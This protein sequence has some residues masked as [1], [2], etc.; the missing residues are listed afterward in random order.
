MNRRGRPRHIYCDRGTNFV[1]TERVLCEELQN[2]DIEQIAD[3]FVGPELSFHFNPPLSPH[4]GGSWK[5]LVKAVEIALHDAL[6]S[7]TPTD[8]LLRSCLISAE[9]IVNSRPLTY[10]P[11][12]SEESEALT[13]NHF[14]VGCSNGDE[15]MAK[16]NNDAKLEVKLRSVLKRFKE[17]GLRLRADK[18]EFCVCQ[19]EFLGFLITEDGISPTNEKIEAIQEAP[20]PTSKL[21][22]QAFLGMLNFFHLFLENKATVAEP[23]HKGISWKWTTEEQNAFDKLKRMLLSYKNLAHYDEKKALLLTC[24]ANPYG[25]GAVLSHLDECGKEVPIAF[26]SRTL[27][28]VIPPRMLRWILILSSYDYKF[29]YVPG[30]QIPHADA[31]SRLPLTSQDKEGPPLQ[32][33]LMLESVPKKS[34]TAEEIAKKTKEDRILSKV[35]FW[36]QTD[37]TDD[38]NKVPEEL[39]QF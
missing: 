16:L 7:R 6:P 30:T 35:S 11:L 39:K 25:V 31:L 29:V 28:K 33:V 5:R 38:K 22:L 18:C 9:N 24:N 4:M 34:I 26:H 13:S 14:L 27:S 21:E 36:I 12:D 37:W 19:V 10:L 2:F 17:D 23:L 8:P 15:S 20:A 32:E 1:A 3:S